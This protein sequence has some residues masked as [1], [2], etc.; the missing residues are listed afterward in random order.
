MNVS[1]IVKGKDNRI[2]LIASRITT[3]V[4]N[5]IKS[6]GCQEIAYRQSEDAPEQEAEVLAVQDI[7]PVSS[8]LT[9]AESLYNSLACQ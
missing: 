5:K 6:L 7:C 4:L 3:V 2:H 8:G 9:S 1:Y